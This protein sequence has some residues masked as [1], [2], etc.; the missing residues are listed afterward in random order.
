MPATPARI[1][2]VTQQYR[3]AI[4]GPDAGVES[5]YGDL[6]RD[7][8]PDDP[9]ETFFDSLGDAQAMA[10][11]RLALMKEDRGRFQCALAKSLTFGFGLDY[12]Q[13][14]PS[15][16]VIE[17]E[18]GIGRPAIVAEIRLGLADERVSLLMWG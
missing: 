16:T 5:A 14:C 13:A 18:R 12:S 17:P 9:I 2:F 3:K 15:G 7:T 11:E 8:S 6:A 10:N 1:A 4:A